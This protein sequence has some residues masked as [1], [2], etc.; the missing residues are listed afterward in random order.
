MALEIGFATFFFLFSI[1]A[2][3]IP[4]W[5]KEKD[6]GKEEKNT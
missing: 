2:V 5:E 6:H 4:L 1:F 3:T